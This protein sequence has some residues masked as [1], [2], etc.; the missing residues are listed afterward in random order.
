MGTFVP[1]FKCTSC[2]NSIYCGSGGKK[3]FMSACKCP[4]RNVII[5]KDWLDKPGEKPV[6]VPQK[7]GRKRR[8]RGVNK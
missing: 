7:T 6:V 2:L 3:P 5:N 1:Y 4:D 8:G